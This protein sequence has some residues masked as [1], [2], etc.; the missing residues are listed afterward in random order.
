VSRESHVKGVSSPPKSHSPK[1]VRGGRTT[2]YTFIYLPN[3]T[4]ASRR[5]SIPKSLALGLL[6]VLFGMVGSL[7]GLSYY[8]RHMRSLSAEY[9]KLKAENHNIRSEA[10]ALVNKLQQVQNNLSRVD[11][12]SGQVREEAAQLEPA[13]TKT[14]KIKNG[15]SLIDSSNRKAKSE[16]ESKAAPS[17]ESG[18]AGTLPAGIGPLTREEYEL[19]QKP[20]R[21][22]AVAVGMQLKIDSLE[23][24]SL[25]ETLD[26]IRSRSSFQA[27]SL[28]GLLKELQG[29]REKIAATPTLAPVQGLVTS[30]YGKRV[31]PIT[32]QNRMHQGLDI[33]AP[34]G[35]P[36]R[37]AAQGVVKRVGYAEDYGN[38]VEVSHG[39]GVLS[40]YAHAKVISVKRG[41]KV[42]K[43][44]TIGAVGMTGRTTGP[45][46]HYE[47]EI[48]GR[49]VDPS[50]FINAL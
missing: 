22:S 39:Y 44:E 4:G 12:F 19:S 35:S 21:V 46:L 11:E 17:R 41:D 23:F 48:G 29:Y 45:H 27:E 37:A 20:G 36:I 14:R 7:A 47:I 3:E 18:D 2:S 9:E 49:K 33:A 32:G 28:S 10:A 42:G 26:D 5:I 34:L 43:G 25:F 15:L 16:A 31:S 1:N 13:A 38:Y 50:S 40:R 8:A 30:L 24:K 6:V